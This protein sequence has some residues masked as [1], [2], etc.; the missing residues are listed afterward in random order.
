MKELDKMILMIISGYENSIA[1]IFQIFESID[2]C[3]TFS[4]LFFIF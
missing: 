4:D 2:I 3:S 1:N